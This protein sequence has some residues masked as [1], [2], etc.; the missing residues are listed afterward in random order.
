[1]ALE[2][3]P[4]FRQFL[5]RVCCFT[6]S[7]PPRPVIALRLNPSIRS[8][9]LP[10]S[11]PTSSTSK[12]FKPHA[13]SKGLNL[14]SCPSQ[15]FSIFTHCSIVF[16]V[17]PISYFTVLC[18]ESYTFVL[19]QDERLAESVGAAHEL[20]RVETTSTIGAIVTSLG[21]PPGAVGIVRLSGPSA[22][23]IVGR[24]FRPARKRKTRTW[25]PTS[26]VVEYGVVL[27]SDGNVIDEVYVFINA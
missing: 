27:D 9:C 10:S 18:S 24:V 13:T 2:Y 3:F 6:Q 15:V 16:W 8:Y 25:E 20:G 11:K 7:P 17:V 23:D 12:N 5:R 1:M 19:K 14:A 4:T 22:V 21:G 26:H